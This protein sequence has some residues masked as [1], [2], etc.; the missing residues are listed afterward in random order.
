MDLLERTVNVISTSKKLMKKAILTRNARP[1]ETTSYVAGTANVAVANANV[2]KV[3]LANFADA[4]RINV[5]KVDL[6]RLR[7]SR[8]LY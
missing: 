4:L 7:D 6:F 2:M 1:M 8:I 5:Q 3:M